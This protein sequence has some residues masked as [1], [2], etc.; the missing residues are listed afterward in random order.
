MI[1]KIGM[2]GSKRMPV[3]QMFQLVHLISIIIVVVV[4]L[5]KEAS[6]ASNYSMVKPNCPV[7]CGDLRIPYPFGVGKGCYL[8]K[9]FE[10]TCNKSTLYYSHS[11]LQVFRFSLDHHYATIDGQ[12]AVLCHDNKS[13][14]SFIQSVFSSLDQEFRI[15]GTQN[16]LVAIGCDFFTYITEFES[17]EYISGCSSLCYNTSR[18]SISV[19]PSLDHNI[20]H[21]SCSGIGC[22]Q[23]SLPKDLISFEARSLSINTEGRS[24]AFKPCSIAFIA[25]NN[26]TEFRKFNISGVTHFSVLPGVPTVIDWAVGN[27]SCHDARARSDYVCGPNSYCIESSSNYGIRY[28]CHCSQGYQGNPYLQINGCQDIDEC[29]DTKRYPCPKGALCKNTAG[30]YSCPCPAGHKIDGN[31]TGCITDPGRRLL[32]LIIPLSFGIAIGIL[33]LIATGL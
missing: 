25:E 22:C 24:W 14:Q 9:K 20:N 30:S 4:L 19:P 32:A 6:S 12:A 33:L 18:D 27:I 7:K 11:H 10:V 17:A 15:S 28:R 29:K 5:I 23:T 21:S 13:G 8:N 31:G 2:R 26:F 3:L 16:K 1:I